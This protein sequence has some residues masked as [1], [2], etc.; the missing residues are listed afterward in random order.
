MKEPFFIFQYLTNPRSVGAIFPSSKYLSEKMIEAINFENAEYIVEYGPGTGV[1]T[2]KIL[3][4]RKADTKIILVE[5]NNGFYF[6]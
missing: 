6:F 3:K 5:N 2:E 4:R 1:F